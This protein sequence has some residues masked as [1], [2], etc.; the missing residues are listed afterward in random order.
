MRALRFVW[1]GLLI[2]EPCAAA[3]WGAR[4][5]ATFR[6]PIVLARWTLEG[7]EVKSFRLVVQ[8]CPP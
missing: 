6:D 7:G 5:P 3:P 4:P 2:A 8:F 1:L